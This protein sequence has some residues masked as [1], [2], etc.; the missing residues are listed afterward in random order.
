MVTRAD[1]KSHCPINFA[2]E[3]FGDP[4]SLLVVRDIV[5]FGKSTFGEFSSSSERVSPSVL[6]ARLTRLEDAGILTRTSDP[7]DARRVR[8]S[9]TERGLALVPVL[10]EM[11]NWSA[12]VDPHTDAPAE[13]IA[14]VNRD[15][16]RMT[17]LIIATVREG[18]SIF[19]GP[20]SVVA[21][22]AARDQE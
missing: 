11:A 14:A 20:R 10:L 19:A 15:R 21:R 17:E 2:L 5:Y 7:V 3:I 4:W 6:A 8:Y 22:L 16:A 9:L 13:W 1:G 12:M 18:G